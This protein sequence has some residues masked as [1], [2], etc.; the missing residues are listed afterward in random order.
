MQNTKNIFN[1]IN[2][3]KKLAKDILII[4]F[5]V[6]AVYILL[7]NGY[8]RP[9]PS[10]NTD[11]RNTNWHIYKR[12]HKLL[13]GLTGHNYLELVDDESKVR[14]Q[15]HG[16]A[17]DESKDEIVERADKNG[18]KLKAFAFDYDYYQ[19]KSVGTDTQYK[20]L[21]TDT[22]F[23]FDLD[24]PGIDL[25]SEYK[26]SVLHIWNKAK[27][28]AAAINNKDIDYPRYGFKLLSETENSNGVAHS[29]ILCAGLSDINIG[30]ITPGQYAELINVSP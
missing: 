19:Y 14:G 15:I 6:F 10:I 28:C 21:G 22:P 4:C 26:D 7:N 2:L 24:I 23:S 16:F 8:V 12:E 5:C 9:K 27:L 18:Y 1:K 17:Y 29:V 25:Y 11:N 3:A 30:L 20:S 13:M